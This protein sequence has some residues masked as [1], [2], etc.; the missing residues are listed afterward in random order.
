MTKEL[1]IFGAGASHAAASLPLGHELGWMYFMQCSTLFKMEKG[2]AANSD[3]QK[4]LIK[5]NYF[6][7]FLDAAGK[8]YPELS[9]EKEAWQNKMSRAEIY[10]PEFL[11]SKNKKYFIDEMLAH[12]L[13]NNDLSV[14]KS[15]KKVIYAH[16][17]HKCAYITHNVLF[18][19]FLA[20]QNASDTTIITL[21]FDTL[22]R[23][24]HDNNICI[25]YSVYF[26]ARF[27]SDGVSKAGIGVVHSLVF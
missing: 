12:A 5:F 23:E 17:S 19:K 3:V 26:N 4:K 13:D 7:E 10:Y 22:I 2:S 1:Y 14:F 9:K 6:G 25:D 18:D 27:F 8:M 15:L 24:N 11:L 20:H 21:N 16:L